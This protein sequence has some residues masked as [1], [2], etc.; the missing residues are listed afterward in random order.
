MVEGV[1]PFNH[2]AS[3]CGADEIRVP[4]PSLLLY[5]T[6]MALYQYRLVYIGTNDVKANLISSHHSDLST[7]ARDIPWLHKGCRCVCNELS[8]SLRTVGY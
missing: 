7:A 1:N 4:T 3:P 5:Y 2:F 8:R 6:N